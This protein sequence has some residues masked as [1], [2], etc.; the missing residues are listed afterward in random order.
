MNYQEFLTSKTVLAQTSGLE[1]ALSDIHPSLFDFQKVL[2]QWALRKGKAALFTD[3]GTGKTRLQI[4]FSRLT[5]QRTLILAP[6]SVARQTVTEAA[7]IDVQVHY[8]RS[9]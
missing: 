7:R 2:V 6:L 3:T 1:V 5:G 4:E 8:T 9:G